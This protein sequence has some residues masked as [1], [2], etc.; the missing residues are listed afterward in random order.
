M[1]EKRRS[2]QLDEKAF[3]ERVL[4]DVDTWHPHPWHEHVMV[5][6]PMRMLYQEGVYGRAAT[7]RYVVDEAVFDSESVTARALV[8]GALLA[9]APFVAY[10]HE[11]AA[12][13]PPAA[14]PAPTMENDREGT[15]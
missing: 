6:Q 11:A 7:A 15:R 8:V 14:H 2:G 10:Q 1:N 9:T 3:T 12:H 5:G 13:K 4:V